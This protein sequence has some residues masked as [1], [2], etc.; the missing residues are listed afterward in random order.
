MLG[1][2]VVDMAMVD[3]NNL[4]IKAP[5]SSDSATV[6]KESDRRTAAAVVGVVV[7]P[8]HVHG[9]LGLDSSNLSCSADTERRY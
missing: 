7:V 5:T 2:V 9:P 6:S 1:T 3:I 8:C 4:P